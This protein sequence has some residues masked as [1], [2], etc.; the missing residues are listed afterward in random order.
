MLYG[1][2]VR[3]KVLCGNHINNIEPIS[4]LLK[5]TLQK[6]NQGLQRRVGAIK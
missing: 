3:R 6:S 5:K 1:R 4:L 2:F